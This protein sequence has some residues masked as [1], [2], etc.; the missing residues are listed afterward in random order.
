MSKVKVVSERTVKRQQVLKEREDK[1]LFIN[2]LLKAAAIIDIYSSYRSGNVKGEYI[3]PSFTATYIKSVRSYYKC[4]LNMNYKILRSYEKTLT[5]QR[6]SQGDS[7]ICKARSFLEQ[8][9]QDRSFRKVDDTALTFTLDRQPTDDDLAWAKYTLEDNKIDLKEFHIGEK[10]YTITYEVMAKL[11]C[12]EH[13][14]GT[15]RDKIMTAA[16]VIADKKVVPRLYPR[17]TNALYHGQFA[18]S[19]YTGAS[20]TVGSITESGK[21]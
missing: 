2:K 5:N 16:Q 15:D 1:K 20:I 21:F 8:K 4:T 18:T 12:T 9:Y 6:S 14:Y 7:C 11:T 3:D 17:T 19:D 10:Y 13:M